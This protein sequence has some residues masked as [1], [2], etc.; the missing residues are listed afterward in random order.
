M[1]KYLLLILVV[2]QFCF[3]SCIFGPKSVDVAVK[4]NIKG[5]LEGC[6]TVK[7]KTATINFESEKDYR[8]STTLKLKIDSMLMVEKVKVSVQLLSK[9]KVVI[10]AL[11]PSKKGIS[12]LIDALERGSGSVEIEFCLPEDMAE[13]T[14]G[15]R[16]IRDN[17]KSLRVVSSQLQLSKTP[18]QIRAEKTAAEVAK[19]PPLEISDFLQKPQKE[20]G[21]KG[22]IQMPKDV[23]EI[24]ANLTAKKFEVTHRKTDQEYSDVCGPQDVT[25]AT[26]V[27]SAGDL[28]E[29]VNIESPSLHVYINFFN[30]DRAK[31]LLQKFKANGYKYH[32]EGYGPVSYLSSDCYYYGARVICSGNKMEIIEIWEP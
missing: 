30:V 18:E 10:C 28:I 16:A 1:K 29:T 25:R 19:M 26:L 5:D 7:G 32:D 13:K 24:I 21:Y 27:R 11:Y 15:A 14:E 22:T 17:V 20:G 3:A 8:P 2:M 31:D 4:K 12:S 9:E 6:A 23:N